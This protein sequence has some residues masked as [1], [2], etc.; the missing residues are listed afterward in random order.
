MRWQGGKVTRT[1]KKIDCN[2]WWL[3]AERM[4]GFQG[5]EWERVHEER[6]WV[7]QEMVMKYDLP[8]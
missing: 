1:K 7:G 3:T 6:G 5:L 2:K 8:T 4:P